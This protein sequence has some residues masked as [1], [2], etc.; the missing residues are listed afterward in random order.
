MTADVIPLRPRQDAPVQPIPRSSSGLR[1][2]VL[3]GGMDIGAGMEAARADDVSSKA[4]I[5]K[6]A[7]EARNALDGK[8]V[9]PSLIRGLAARVGTLA[10]AAEQFSAEAKSYGLLKAA[11]QLREHAGLIE[12]LAAELEADLPEGA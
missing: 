11:V 10:S 7:A 2:A 6:L 4:R 5:R 3:R 8:H 9:C 1:E 12:A